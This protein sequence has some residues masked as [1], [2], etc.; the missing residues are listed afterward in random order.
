MQMDRT[1]EEETRQWPH[2]TILRQRGAT[3]HCKLTI[4]QCYAPTNEAAD[5]DN[6]YDSLQSIV[7][8]I[9]RHDL[10]MVIL[11]QK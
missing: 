5:E 4:I 3:K 9:P 8:K 11:M 6:F 7:V 1:R 2:N 10:L